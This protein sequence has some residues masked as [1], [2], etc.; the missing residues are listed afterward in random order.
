MDQV[1]VEL[2]NKIEKAVSEIR[3]QKSEIEALK[4]EKEGNAG[5][6]TEL[7]ARIS[8]LEGLSMRKD[9]EFQEKM[10]SFSGK[11]GGIIKQLDSVF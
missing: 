6:I 4:T 2:E 11:V 5:K 10:R 1:L 3:R 9:E 8:E 7:E